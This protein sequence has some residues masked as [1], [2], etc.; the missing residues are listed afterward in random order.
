M[1][2]RSMFLSN[3]ALRTQPY[4]MRPSPRLAFLQPFRRFG[5]R[6]DAVAIDVV[7]MRG[8]ISASLQS[9]DNFRGAFVG[10][11]LN[12]AGGGTAHDGAGEGS[13]VDPAHR[14]VNVVHCAELSLRHHVGL[15]ASV[16]SVT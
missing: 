11:L 9:I 12:E 13:A 10:E 14:A 2:R 3:S 16:G 15:D 1:L 6:G 8:I 7:G 5:E 4:T